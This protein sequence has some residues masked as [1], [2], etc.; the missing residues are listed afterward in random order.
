MR[1][2]FHTLAV[3]LL[4]ATSTAH[5]QNWTLA[6]HAGGS[7]QDYGQ[8]VAIDGDDNSYLIGEFSGTAMFDTISLTGPG[9]WNLFLAKYNRQG[10]IVSASTVAYTTASTSDLYANAIALDRWGNIYIAG[11]FLTDLNFSGS[12][13][14]SVGSSDMFLAKLN[15]RGDLLWL[16]TPGGVGNGSFGQDGI[17][18]I[19][20]DSSG[21]CHVTGHY[22][23]DALFDSIA[24]SSSLTYEMFVAKYDS[25]GKVLWVRSAGGAGALHLGLGIAADSAGNSY[26]TGRFFNT[27][28]LGPYTFDAGDAEQKAFIAKIDPDGSFLWA[29][30]IGSGSYYGAGEDIAVD[31]NGD[32]C[33]AGQFRS[34]IRFGSIEHT[35]NNALNYAVLI[36]RYD[37]A[38]TYLW[39]ARSDGQE[40]SA[41]SSKLCLDDNGNAYV[42]GEFSGTIGFG[43]T[44]LS[45][46]RKSAFVAKL[47]RNGRWVLAGKIDGSGTAEGNGIAITSDG[48]C[49]VTG[50]FTDSISIGSR[51]LQSSGGYDLFL[52]RL[53]QK[54]SSV[55]VDHDR[56]MSGPIIYPNPAGDILHV[57]NASSRG[58]IQ[59]LS[60]AGVRLMETDDRERI[61]ISRLPSGVYFIEVDGRV[62][63]FIKEGTR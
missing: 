10:R 54:E 40:Q 4:F 9:R 1:S 32:A 3:I 38:G 35:Y 51:Q 7:A 6:E 52:A 14:T 37:S 15:R 30:E 59:I 63:P 56:P 11:R 22:N 2:I 60:I 46:P 41:S 33:V 48:D 19:A 17:T 62:V 23:S 26:C 27:L 42:T 61:D 31:R 8:R 57:K 58:R 43:S 24:L 44:S 47:D 25:S 18:S 13:R 50:S 49:E 53:G 16:R 12:V 34:T 28:T 45:G 5:S 29:H 39:S 21:N 55:E 20:L 36:V